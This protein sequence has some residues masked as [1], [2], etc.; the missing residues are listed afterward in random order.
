M[1]EETTEEVATETAEAATEGTT[2]ETNEVATTGDMDVNDLVDNANK[3]EPTGEE[4]VTNYY[5]FEISETMK[6][7]PLGIR[8]MD[9][10]NPTQADFDNRLEGE[11]KP[12]TDAIR[13]LN[14][15][16]GQFYINGDA[17]FVS[18]LK[19]HALHNEDKANTDKRYFN[20]V[21]TGERESQK[22]KY[23]LFSI[24]PLS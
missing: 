11:D 5:K 18:T 7:L 15:K 6:V 3:M 2:E 24:Q 8:R 10:K 16:D 13:F 1:S 12:M 19:K 20:I 17:V 4:L 9:K 21:V 23:L 14:C 22:G